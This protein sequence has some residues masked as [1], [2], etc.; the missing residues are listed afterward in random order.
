[1]NFSTQIENE[2]EM[3]DNELISP[4]NSALG[5]WSAAHRDR[6]S[7]ESRESARESTRERESEST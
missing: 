4:D 2:N 7:V 3:R 1:M 6:L 5:A